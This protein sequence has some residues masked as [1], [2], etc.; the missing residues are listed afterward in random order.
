MLFRLTSSREVLVDEVIFGLMTCKVEIVQ[1]NGQTIWTVQRGAPVVWWTAHVDEDVVPVDYWVNGSWWSLML[2][3]R[4]KERL[5]GGCTLFSDTKTGDARPRAKQKKCDEG[6]ARRAEC[7]LLAN[8]GNLMLTQ[9]LLNHIPGLLCVPHV[10][11][12]SEDAI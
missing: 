5:H 12:R 9:T 8:Y 4:C 6:N 2:T 3:M 1:P 11:H 7:T 10:L